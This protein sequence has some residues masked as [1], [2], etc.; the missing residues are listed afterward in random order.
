MDV[1]KKVQEII[2][3]VP[4]PTDDELKRQRYY[5]KLREASEKYLQKK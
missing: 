1:F 5:L 3:S 4:A 2:D